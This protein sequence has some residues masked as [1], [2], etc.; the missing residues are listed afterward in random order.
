MYAQLQKAEFAL[1]EGDRS[2]KIGLSNDL[3]PIWK[4]ADQYCKYSN[5]QVLT[6]DQV[7]WDKYDFLLVLLLVP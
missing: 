5:Y 7:R 6:H 3:W 1:N 4:G 2:R